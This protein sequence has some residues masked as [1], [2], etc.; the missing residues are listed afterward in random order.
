MKKVICVTESL[1]GGGAEHQMVILADLLNQQGYEVEMVTFADVPDHYSVPQNVKRTKLGIGKGLLGQTWDI[2][3]FFIKV[4]TDCVISYRQCSNARVSIPLLFRRIKLISG[5]RN[6]T[7][8]K[9]D[10][11]EKLLINMGLC[12]RS[13]YIVPNSYTQGR[14]IEKIKPCWKDKIIPIINY[15]DLNQ[16]KPSTIPEDSSV[17][18]IA[19]FSR[20]SSQKNPIR[21]IEMLNILKKQASTAFEIH[22]YGQQKGKN[23]EF[24]K[25]YLLCKQTIEDNCVSD[26]IKLLSAVPD[27]SVLMNDYH[28]ICLPSLFEGFSNSVAEA[29]CSGKVMLCSDVSD[30]SLMVEDGVNGFLFDPTSIDS[31]VSCFKKFFSKSRESII[32]MGMH[33]RMKAEKLFDKDNFIN[34][35]I[36]LIEF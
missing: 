9:R 24:D 34:A 35:Y 17:M 26:V 23:G 33:S 29:I 14:Y 13:N 25:D 15:T 21:F 28:A 5:E 3:K 12:S 32:K 4:K 18:K 27:P 11:F 2:F 8:G 6:T 22:W 19:V 36:K 31:M 16:F 1:A 10:K 30:N 7:Y 20:F